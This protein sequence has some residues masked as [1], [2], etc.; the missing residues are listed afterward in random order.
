MP[1]IFIIVHML[2][3]FKQ[4]YAENAAVFPDRDSF[5]G[6]FGNI[7]KHKKHNISEVFFKW[8]TWV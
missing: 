7:Q 6:S 1:K 4:N 5:G 8:N 2:K 3:V